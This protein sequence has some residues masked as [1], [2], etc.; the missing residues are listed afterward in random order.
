MRITVTCQTERSQHQNKATALKILKSKLFK[1]EEEKKEE[2]EAKLKGGVQKAEWGRQ[3]RSYVMQPYQLVK[4]H[5]TD[6]ET[7]DIKA[8]LD[9]D[10]DGFIEAYLKKVKSL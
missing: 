4:D 5:R 8:V 3:V 1:L 10:L 7:S 2:A 6:Y 9:G